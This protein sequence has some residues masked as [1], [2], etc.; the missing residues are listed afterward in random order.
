MV[1]DVVPELREKIDT[2]FTRHCMRDRRLTQIS[3]RVRDG[4]PRRSDGHDYAEALGENLS[5]A[6]LETL[7]PE[8]LPNETLYYNIAERTVVPSLE[9]THKMVNDMAADIQKIQDTKNGIGLG[10]IPAKFP[11]S[12]INGLIDKMTTEGI[13]IED[14]L[15]WL[16]EPIINNS[17]A[18]YDDFVKDNAEL[19][20]EMGLR[21]TI[22]RTV[23]PGCCDWCDAMAGTYEYGKEPDDIYRR[24][25]FCRCSVTFQSEKRSQNVWT[26]KT[27]QS[28]PEEIARRESI[29]Q[30]SEMSA[31]EMIEAANQAYR[32]Q[33]VQKFQTETGAGRSYARAA[34][35]RKNPSEIEA[36]IAKYREDIEAKK[37]GR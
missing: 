17:E 13:T 24:H 28:S 30:R 20:T 35:L 34:T 8:A 15:K 26:K 14:A 18:F 37:S 21:S 10:S 7:T 33:N 1:Q 25:E 11:E 3:N 16:K 31:R 2:S 23:A 4:T 19:R 29:G 36:A 22:T 27:W 9:E 32:D 12:R 5:K 6:L